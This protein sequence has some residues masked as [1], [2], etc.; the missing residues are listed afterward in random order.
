MDLL[1]SFQSLLLCDSSE[2][3]GPEVKGKPRSQ[4]ITE[5]MLEVSPVLTKEHN[6]RSFLGQHFCR[7]SRWIFC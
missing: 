5:N 4:S 3:A 2:Y 6:P 7:H 1:K